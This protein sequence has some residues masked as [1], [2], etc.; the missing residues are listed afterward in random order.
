MN[1]EQTTPTVE[2]DDESGVIQTPA[3]IVYTQAPVQLGRLVSLGDSG[4]AVVEVG[5]APIQCDIDPSV[6][7]ALLEEALRTKARLLLENGNKPLVVGVVATQRSL[8]IDREGR[9]SADLTALSVKV[10][11]EVVLRTR[12]AFLRVKGR[13]VESYA[14]EIITRA[15][16][17]VRLL[18]ALIR[19]N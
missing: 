12:E 7:P 19:M 2:L 6:D 1:A 11:E 18:G 14:G 8:S 4:G 17:T 10:K 5:G 13:E 9:V 16:D 15:R 3:R